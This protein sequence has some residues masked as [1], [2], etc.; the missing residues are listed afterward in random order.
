VL[1]VARNG[2]G[3]LLKNA[4]KK[5]LGERLTLASNGQVR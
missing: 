5:E 1:K 2:N 3:K 4:F